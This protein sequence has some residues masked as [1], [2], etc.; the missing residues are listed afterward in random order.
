MKY[1]DIHYTVLLSYLYIWNFQNKNFGGKNLSS[2][3]LSSQKAFLT[4]LAE[5]FFSILSI[6]TGL[7]I[8]LL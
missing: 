6:P 3:V 8:H 5:L 1:M 2:D 4:F 7:S